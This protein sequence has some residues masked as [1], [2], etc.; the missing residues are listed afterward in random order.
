MSRVSGPQPSGLGNG[1]ELQTP[2][3]E[4]EV[5]KTQTRGKKEKSRTWTWSARLGERHPFGGTLLPNAVQQDSFQV[6]PLPTPLGWDRLPRTGWDCDR[7]TRVSAGQWFSLYLTG[8]YDALQKHRA[9]G[10]AA[11]NPHL[12]TLN[13][14]EPHACSSIFPGDCDGLPN[15][16]YS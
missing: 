8:T 7:H 14:A 12:P 3:G 4:T 6:V 5:Q 9:L 1:A 11:E 2:A 13:G 16:V 10:P 15:S